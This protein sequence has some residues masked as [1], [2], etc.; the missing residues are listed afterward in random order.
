MHRSKSNPLMSGSDHLRHWRLKPGIGLFPLTPKSGHSENALIVIAV[1]AEVRLG[2]SVPGP[3]SGRTP[4]Q[5]PDWAPRNHSAPLPR[6]AI[7]MRPT[8]TSIQRADKRRNAPDFRGGKF[9]YAQIAPEPEGLGGWGAG[10][11][12]V[13]GALGQE[14][15]SASRCSANPMHDARFR[16]R[17]QK[18]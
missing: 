10:S 1:T 3:R 18:H 9:Q 13:A 2:T 12:A 5:E 16:F 11:G 7:S 17:P 15:R 6:G 8:R 4:T 14:P